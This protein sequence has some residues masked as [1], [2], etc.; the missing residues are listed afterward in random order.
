MAPIPPKFK[1][2]TYSG[3]AEDAATA[4]SVAEPAPPPQPAQPVSPLQRAEQASESVQ[5]QRPAPM[6]TEAP[7][8]PHAPLPGTPVQQVVNPIVAPPLPPY[9]TGAPPA[10]NENLPGPRVGKPAPF[11][12]QQTGAPTAP[13]PPTPETPLLA[14]SKAFKP[15][16]PYPFAQAFGKSALGEFLGPAWNAIRSADLVVEASKFKE[17]PTYHVENDP[18]VN[19]NPDLLKQVMI[20][21]SPQ[22]TRYILS[23]LQDEAEENRR[24]AQS[25]LSADLG[26]TTG[27]LLN[28]LNYIG[29]GEFDAVPKLISAGADVTTR[30]M[31]RTGI[32]A[33]KFLGTNAVVGG[34]A[35]GL[36]PNA[37]SGTFANQMIANLGILMFF[38]LGRNFMGGKPDA[39]LP[40]EKPAQLP[41][42][43]QPEPGAGETLSG[44]PPSE[45]G[46]ANLRKRMGGGS[47]GADSV[48]PAE[49]A[50]SGMAAQTQAVDPVGHP[51]PPK[52]PLGQ[53]GPHPPENFE[54][55]A[56]AVTNAESTTF[57]ANI[58]RRDENGKIWGGIGRMQV[59]L[60]T[61]RD[62]AR[63]LHDNVALSLDDEGLAKYLLEPSKSDPN[64]ANSEVYGRHYLQQQL[65]K[66]GDQTLATLA[67]TEG[68]GAVDAAIAKYGDPRTGK[69]SY[70]DF[71][72]EFPDRKAYMETVEKGAPPKEVA[73]GDH[74][75]QAAD[76]AGPTSVLH[77]GEPTAP[78]AASIPLDQIGFVDAK[79][80]PTEA[81]TAAA[82]TITPKP[83]LSL[84]AGPEETAK[85]N[86]IAAAFARTH[87][88]S[89][90]KWY[91]ADG[92][93]LPGPD[94]ASSARVMPDGTSPA[95]PRDAAGEPLSGFW[96][97]IQSIQ[98][99]SDQVVK[100]FSGA[101]E[102]MRTIQG[103]IK[104][105]KIKK[106]KLGESELARNTPGT[107]TYAQSQ[108]M[109]GKAAQS[110]HGLPKPPKS[111]VERLA[112]SPSK[113]A[114]DGPAK[115]TG[116]GY[117]ITS[118][119]QALVKTV[120]QAR[121]EMQDGV[122]T[123]MQETRAAYGEY[124]ARMNKAQPWN[125]MSFQEFLSEVGK[126]KRYAGTSDAARIAPEAV[127][128]A[129][130]WERNFYKPLQ[131]R[132]EKV[133]LNPAYQPNF[134]NRVWNQQAI[135][136]NEAAL[137]RTIMGQGRSAA[138]ADAA[139]A[140]LQ[141]GNP[142]T[143]GGRDAAVRTPDPTAGIP[144]KAL[145]PF[146]VHDI[147]TNAE[148][149]LNTHGVDVALAE[150]FGDPNM[151]DHLAQI[152]DDY[153]KILETVSDPKQKAA[154]EQ[155][156]GRD[157]ADTRN[158]RDTTRGNIGSIDNLQAHITPAVAVAPQH[159]L[160]GL[161]A[162]FGLW[163]FAMS[164]LP[165]LG[166]VG[167]AIGAPLLLL[168]KGLAAVGM[169]KKMAQRVSDAAGIAMAAQSGGLEGAGKAFASSKFGHEMLHTVFE[170]GMHAM[171]LGGFFHG[172]K[173]IKAL[174]H[175]WGGTGI[176]DDIKQ[177][178]AG[179]ASNATLQRLVDSGLIA[180]T[181]EGEKDDNLIRRIFG[182]YQNHGLDIG[183][184][185]FANT[186]HWNDTEA[187]DAFQRALG[188][189]TQSAVTM[190]QSGPRVGW[191]TDAHQAV[192]DHLRTY[193]YTALHKV[194][195]PGLP[196]RDRQ[197]LTAVATN[198]GLGYLSAAGQK[199]ARGENFS[200]KEWSQQLSDALDHSQLKVWPMNTTDAMRGLR[201]GNIGLRPYLGLGGPGDLTYEAGRAGG[202]AGS[203]A[204]NLMNSVFANRYDPATQQMQNRY[205]PLHTIW[206]TTSLLHRAAKD[207]A[208]SAAGPP[209][210][211]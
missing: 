166:G 169:V 192:L 143:I 200:G 145:E 195:T 57:N 91:D 175:Q 191:V 39:A 10:G 178:V 24:L 107:T 153:A 202:P 172:I 211:L 112:N 48:A 74:V 148:A 118:D 81:G 101:E 206:Q 36:D 11:I 30:D 132:G 120:E 140:E 125:I 162:K 87:P 56:Q 44:A 171:G 50:S 139:I 116:T 9:M 113:T 203:T 135:A 106:S 190:G 32:G 52:A 177:A 47:A 38:G 201:N 33:A 80:N 27:A 17:D 138:D 196:E 69:I 28:P 108:H 168:G 199:T 99:W 72:A 154:L 155:M 109:Y 1:P 158:I 68:P 103:A 84:D 167:A 197:F 204:I 131:D 62:I 124:T 15:A 60:P 142:F 77:A 105:G 152:R 97:H 198:M 164:H 45:Q 86:D 147:K 156:A 123:A 193:L 104:T 29:L 31:L 130:S 210:R 127:K 136:S 179:K 78:A 160:L 117:G 8:G 89:D 194:L 98:G 150:H 42:D 159:P 67:Y 133:G 207:H 13:A 2:P 46:I 73:A 110:A 25:G 35:S 66:Y 95:I 14:P 92:K 41:A 51:A 21:R 184:L 186:D 176:L 188:N 161:A 122:D 83:I 102:A 4:A 19:Q 182:E 12:W 65:D 34:I 90:L 88:M 183:S 146:L 40:A 49:N 115:I 189:E 79:G 157:I 100:W 58:I 173:Q 174:A 37:P 134:M 53:S 93:P 6:S 119:G 187:A 76:G 209:L 70:A 208:M 114:R 26:G 111:P 128:A 181:R 185:R 63:D 96:K 7:I 94:G 5:F 165:L 20:S 141:K 82:A 170:G 137:R 75:S 23:R 16:E 64:L 54:S 151:V 205:V 18:L 163:G 59:E 71:K 149:H 129:G 43:L 121:G 3:A 180:T 55:W 61:A 144:D 85:A 126:A 22:A